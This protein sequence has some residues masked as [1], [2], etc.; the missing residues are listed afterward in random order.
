MEGTSFINPM[1]M[2][3]SLEGIGKTLGTAG[4][5]EALSESSGISSFSDIIKNAIDCQQGS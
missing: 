3:G 5:A 2:W 1:N 4:T